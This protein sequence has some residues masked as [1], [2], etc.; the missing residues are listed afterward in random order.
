MLSVRQNLRVDAE[1]HVG[2]VTKTITVTAEAAL[3]DTASGTVSNLVDDRRIVDLPLNGRNVMSLAQLVPGVLGVQAPES[4]TSAR[5]GPQMNAN[6]GRG[7]Q[8]LY[9]F[10]GAFFN[11]PSRNTGMNYP[12]PDAV[13]EFRLLTSNFDA[14]YGRNSGSQATA[15]ARAG[16]NG[17]HG[18]VWEFLRN[19]ALNARNFFASTVPAIKERSSASLAPT[20]DCETGRKGWRRRPWCPRR[21]SAMGTS[22]TYCLARCW[23]TLRIPIPARPF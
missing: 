13:Q 17:F 8:N 9:T 22:R 18:D 4:L 11:N 2:A 23:A 1:L 21:R 12:P 16:T 20:R 14:E 15:V 3:V 7:N 10:D 6:G 5:G 19:D